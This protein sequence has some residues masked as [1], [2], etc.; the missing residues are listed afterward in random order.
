MSLRLRSGIAN[1]GQLGSRR[2]FPL[3]SNAGAIRRAVAEADL[4]V[5]A[6]LVPGE[7]APVVVPEEFV[8]A[9][10]PGSVVVDV[11]AGK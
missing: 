1:F 5:G 7:R 10:Q 8:E 11:A 4:L 3:A 2:I 9:M 6:V